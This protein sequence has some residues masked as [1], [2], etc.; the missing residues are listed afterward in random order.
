M[1]TA[2]T[3]AMATMELSEMPMPSPRY[4]AVSTWWM[5]KPPDSRSSPDVL[6]DAATNMDAAKT[7]M[8]ATSPNVIETKKILE[9]DRE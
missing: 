1:S 2:T 8:D 5:D 4:P 7:T 3:R 6:W 9:L